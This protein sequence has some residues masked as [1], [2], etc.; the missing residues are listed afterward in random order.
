MRDVDLFQ[1]ALGLE[2]PWFVDRTEFDAEAKRLDLYL[3]FRKG[4]RFRC[5]ECGKGG[6]PAHDTSE[7]TWR[8][9]NFFQHE[10]FLHARVPR[11]ACETCGVKRVE[12]PWARTG[13][14]FTLLFEAMVLALVKSMPVAAVARLVGEQDTRLWRVVHHY[15]EV[16]REEVS[17]AAV[18]RVGV[19][20][21]SLKRGHHY[22]TLF[23]D[24][25]GTRV[26]FATEGREADT[27]RAFR[28]DLEAHGGH[29]DRIWEVCM[30]MSPAYRKGQREHLPHA[31]ITFDRFHVVK[32]LNEAV[33]QVRRA[34]RKEAPELSRTRYLWLKNASNLSR[35]QQ[36]HLDQLL[37]GQSHLRTVKAYQM[38]LAFQDF[39]E[40]SASEAGRFL[41]AW[42]SWARGSELGP[43]ARFAQTVEQHRQ[44][45]LRWFQTRISNGLLEGLSSLVQAAKARAR[46]YR[47]THNLIAILYLM[48]GKLPLHP[49]T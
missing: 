42:C 24:L 40:L 3:D 7:K 17:H 48:H 32:L 2:T 36:R 27:F 31:R 18:R 19:D 8:H 45:I 9:L 15:V 34:E 47:S 38:K 21:T 22:L 39:W 10:A 44:G 1:M 33:D 5:P 46:G 20:E 30:D 13:S 35:S 4:G 41:D 28:E 16:A 25:D 14:G 49:P 43:M 26:L 37:L 29:P 11:V 6:C 23:V 12:V